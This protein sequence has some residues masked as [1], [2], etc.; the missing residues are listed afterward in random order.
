M[1]RINRIHITVLAV[2]LL[3][4]AL[5]PSFL[6]RVNYEQSRKNVVVAVSYND[7]A[8]KLGQESLEKILRNY[9][10]AGVTV[11]NV[12]EEDVDSMSGRGEFTSLT[13]GDL[14]HKYDEESVALAEAVAQQAPQADYISRVLLTK[15]PAMADFLAE[16]L[17]LRKT[18]EEFTRV[19]AEGTTL[20]VIYDGRTKELNE[21]LGYDEAALTRLQE[22]GFEIAL[23]LRVQDS[24]S[25]AYL[26]HLE[27]IVEKYG[28][29]Y[30]QLAASLEKGDDEQV[31]KANYEG[32]SRVIRD[33][34]LTLVINEDP[35]QLSN[36]APFGYAQ[37]FGETCDRVIRAY[38]NPVTKYTT[39]ADKA[40]ALYTMYFNSTIDRHIRFINIA[41]VDEVEKSFDTISQITVD[42][43]RQYIDKITSLGYTV[44][45]ETEAMDYRVDRT[46]IYVVSAAIMVLLCYLMFV[47]LTG[48]TDARWNLAAAIL[49]VLA[50]GASF[51]MPAGLTAL[52]PT[53]WAVIMPC[54]CITAVFGFIKYK[55][56]KIPAA[57]L[58]AL[59]P[60]LAVL[61]MYAGGIV[62]CSMLSGI[63]YYMNNLVFRG[64]K[65]SLILPILFGLVA[66]FFL[67]MDTKKYLSVSG[68]RQLLTSR[69]QVNWVLLAGAA[70]VVAYVYLL[71]SGNVNTISSM[72]R[73]M[74]DTLSEMFAA[75]P[76][77][78]EFL[79]GY[80]C[81]ALFAYYRK[82]TKL[83]LVQAALAAGGSIVIAS[84]SNSYCHVFTDALAI[85]SRTLNGL[86]V[87][88]VVCVAAYL[89]N[90]LLVK[91]VK[92]VYGHIIR[93]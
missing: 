20:F 81:L 31:R 1:K 13:Y 75:R 30:L 3:V 41:Q 26:E 16:R 79:I 2:I 51:V 62:M 35:D 21:L 80:P 7:L 54:F 93:Q 24:S 40:Y 33:H 36:S 28:V 9:Y 64:V 56:E 92:T 12:P 59:A 19:E 15:D 68:V 14:I 65:L 25:T 46:F 23:S 82:Q 38:E 63:D 32:L 83:P 45:G 58:S 66:Y 91:I 47:M 5:V 52:Y 57:L 73:L 72:E 84:V 10:D 67:F 78:K 88:A 87:G 44:N 29:R 22:M 43:A 90:L 70:G 77:T 4:L 27:Y 17:A 39:E 49:A 55:A 37:I 85:Y 18:A 53:A 8:N 61:L 48:N 76:R 11:V 50:A 71:R 42:A 60:V 86:I 89:A 6:T 34:G 74:R 69:I